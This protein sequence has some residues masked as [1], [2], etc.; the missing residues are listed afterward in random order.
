MDQKPIIKY[1]FET[2]YGQNFHNA[3][4]GKEPEI[5]V[6]THCTLDPD[7][8]EDIDHF[9]RDRFQNACLYVTYQDSQGHTWLL[10]TVN[11]PR[12][13][14]SGANK[15]ILTPGGRRDYDYGF[16]HTALSELSEETCVFPEDIIRICPSAQI[17]YIG[18]ED[19]MGKR[20]GM[21]FSSQIHVYHLRLGMLTEEDALT[22]KS[23][24]REQPS[25][26]IL[27][28]KFVDIDMIINGKAKTVDGL[29][30]SA[31]TL[32]L[33]KG[34]EKMIQKL[35]V[36]NVPFHY[37]LFQEIYAEI[38][39]FGAAKVNILLKKLSPEEHPRRRLALLKLILLSLE[40]SKVR[41]IMDK[42]DDLTQQY[43][44]DLV[45]RFFILTTISVNEAAKIADVSRWSDA[46]VVQEALEK[47]SSDQQR[48]L[49][50]Q[51]YIIDCPN[52]ALSRE[53]RRVLT[54]DL[55]NQINAAAI[56]QADQQKKL[57]LSL[58]EAVSQDNLAS[59]SKWLQ[60]DADI[61]FQDEKGFSVLHM[62]PSLKMTEFLLQHGA[63]TELTLSC[64]LNEIDYRGFTPLHWHVVEGHVDIV[65]CLL[66]GG[67]KVD[68]KSEQGVTPLF[69]AAKKNIEIGKV[70]EDQN[71]AM[72]EM[73][74]MR[75]ANVRDRTV[76]GHF[77]MGC[78]YG[79]Q[80]MTDKFS[81]ISFFTEELLGEQASRGMRAWRTAQQ[82]KND[83]HLLE[84]R[85][86]ALEK[87]CAIFAA[88]EKGLHQS[89]EYLQSVLGINQQAAAVHVPLA[90]TAA[91][92]G[93]QPRSNKNKHEM[94]PQPT[95]SKSFLSP[96]K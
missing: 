40:F 53:L 54:R 62:A 19:F 60:E 83:I 92:V 94:E 23:L 30:S 56:R 78:P 71:R 58:L 82:Q 41:S 76:K 48:F 61:C 91:Q 8:V 87:K 96:S 39:K 45:E 67:A 4:T 77:V 89:I 65:G 73:L 50:A 31:P 29:I 95:T 37:R 17:S 86:Q 2:E 9:N 46:K 14:D 66:E 10:V 44:H 25:E 36:T 90:G 74:V 79:H 51:K 6:V 1:P 59:C 42:L 34:V 32:R 43:F 49:I 85:Q 21:N 28:A 57:G 38:G 72:T 80:G 24:V 26:E 55:T 52:E 18:C 16:L 70:S 93:S 27:M 88:E 64:I 11:Q 22:L 33:H 20:Y 75:G 47:A 68:A 69:M 35:F 63:N 3:W 12:V 7:V 84:D 81:N 15:A 13:L 5:S